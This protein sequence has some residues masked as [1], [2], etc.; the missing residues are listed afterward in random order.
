VMKEQ[1]PDFRNLLFSVA[2]NPTFH[3]H[4]SFPII[5]IFTCDVLCTRYTLT[6]IISNPSVNAL[7]E[8][9]P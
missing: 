5:S 2:F 3:I 8:R 9:N 7:S 1:S 4:G 6:K